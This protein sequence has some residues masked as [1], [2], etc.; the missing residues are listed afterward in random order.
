MLQPSRL[1]IAV[2][3][4]LTLT[5]CGQRVAVTVSD[6]PTDHQGVTVA[7]TELLDELVDNDGLID[8]EGLAADERALDRAVA[9][10]G[11]AAL[12]DGSEARLAYLLNAYHVLAMKAVLVHGLPRSLDSYFDRASFYGRTTF[13]VAGRWLTLGEVVD[14]LIV[15]T[16][17]PRVY[18]ALNAMV[19]SCPRLRRRAYRAADLDAALD[20]AM[21]EFVNDPHHLRYDPAAGSLTLSPLFKR[22]RDALD[23][24]DAAPLAL[25]HR[26]GIEPPAGCTI[27]YTAWDWRVIHRQQPVD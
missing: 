11:A 8:F 5:A 6:Y 26:Y 9:G 19:H 18:A 21:R 1:L 13:T 17:E 23:A 25:L 3:V 7:C 20:A 10:I 12:P 16:R 24:D 2:F 4:A 27:R 14:E 15:P 22:Y